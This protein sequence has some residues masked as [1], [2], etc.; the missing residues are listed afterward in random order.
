MVDFVE[1]VPNNHFR[2]VSYEE[3]IEW[4]EIDYTAAVVKEMSDE[5]NIESV[6]NQ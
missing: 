4:I 6:V 2:D 1:A 5:Q 3:V